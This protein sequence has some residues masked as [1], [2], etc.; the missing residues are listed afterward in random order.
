MFWKIGTVEASKWDVA[1]KH[2][3]FDQHLLC[4]MLP[5]AKDVF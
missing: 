3:L 2:E 1:L 4:E 5:K